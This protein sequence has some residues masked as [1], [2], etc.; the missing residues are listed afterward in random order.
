[1]H[2]TSSWHKN[3]NRLDYTHTNPR[4]QG[5]TSLQGDGGWWSRQHHVLERDVAMYWLRDD[6]G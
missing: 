5:E 6:T 1:M 3:R 4:N 2:T